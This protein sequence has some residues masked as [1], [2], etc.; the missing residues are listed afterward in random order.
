M[1]KILLFLIIS[2]LIFFIS[3]CEYFTLMSKSE[4]NEKSDQE[5]DNVIIYASGARYVTRIGNYIPYYWK[6]TKDDHE[7]VN[8]ESNDN[9]GVAYSIYVVGDTVYTCGFYSS[10]SLTSKSYFSSFIQ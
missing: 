8:L 4:W 3:N 6:I 10:G 9:W 7:M 1:K 5:E 2:S